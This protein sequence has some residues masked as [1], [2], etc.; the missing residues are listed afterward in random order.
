MLKI[1]K[2][3][4]N[5]NM[6]IQKNSPILLFPGLGGSKLIK[7]NIDIWPPKLSYYLFSYNKWYKSIIVKSENNS[8]LYDKNVKT[9][10]FGD[11]NSLDLHSNIPYIIKKNFYENILNSKHD[12]YPMPYDFRLLHNKNYIDE[13]YIKIKKYIESFNKPVILLTHSCGGLL[14][15]YFLTKQNIIWK[16]QHI[17]KVI[18]V[19][20]PFGSLIISL[21][22]IIKKSFIHLFLNIESLKSIGG[23]IINLPNKKILKPILIINNKE[24]DDYYKYFNLSQLEKII[25]NNKDMI[26]SFSKPNQVKTI[27]VYTSNIKTSSIINIKNNKIKIIKGPGDGTV[28]LASLLYPLLWKQSNLKIVHLPNYEH[29]SIL[30][31]K[32]LLNII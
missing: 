6:I 14:V 17:K 7:N 19:N 24:I 2:F 21:E 27:V 16:K 15:H 23:L 12:V 4:L 3:F 31:S 30:F 29:S 26:N 32:E 5:F 28:P 20:V 1:I 18:Y 9:L 25:E 11:K 22:H 10:E 8:F 13:L